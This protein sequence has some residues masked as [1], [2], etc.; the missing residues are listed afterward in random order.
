M[1]EYRSVLREELSVTVTR[2][3]LRALTDRKVAY[4]ALR[5][6]KYLFFPFPAD[7]LAITGGG[8]LAYRFFPD[9]KRFFGEYWH[10]TVWGGPNGTLTYGTQSSTPTFLSEDQKYNETNSFCCLSLGSNDC[11]RLRG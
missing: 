3:T 11:F 8:H 7:L 4:C 5:S 1:D 9:R 2:V 6:S 10:Q